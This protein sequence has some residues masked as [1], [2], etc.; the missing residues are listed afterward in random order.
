VDLPFKSFFSGYI[1]L[2]PL[3]QIEACD[4]WDGY[5]SPRMFGLYKPFYEMLCR[6]KLKDH[7]E[8]N[9]YMQ[10]GIQRL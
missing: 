1:V 4:W 6:R 5:I 10:Q 2:A 3:D 9:Q 8:A 7:K